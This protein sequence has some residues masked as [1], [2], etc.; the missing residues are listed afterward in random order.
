MKQTNHNKPPEPLKSF[1]K[2]TSTQKHIS[3]PATASKDCRHQTDHILR[4]HSW[5]RAGPTPMCSW[6]LLDAWVQPKARWWPE[7]DVPTWW[8]CR[9]YPTQSDTS[10]VAL[11]LGDSKR[12][13]T[14]IMN[15]AKTWDRKNGNRWLRWFLFTY[16]HLGC[17]NFGNKTNKDEES[18]RIVEWHRRHTVD[19]LRCAIWQTISGFEAV[20]WHIPWNDSCKEALRIWGKVSQLRI[21]HGMPLTPLCKVAMAGRLAQSFENQVSARNAM[22]TWQEPFNVQHLQAS[23][24]ST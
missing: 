12:S 11:A 15:N 22:F 1:Q 18:W 8:T 19:I 23:W 9:K 16:L 14:T 13:P 24:S 5:W 4:Y 10:T 17:S 7:K 20:A 6:N 2:K 3:G 21:A